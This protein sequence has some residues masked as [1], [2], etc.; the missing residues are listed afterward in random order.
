MKQILVRQDREWVTKDTRQFILVVPDDVKLSDLDKDVIADL[1]DKKEVY[2]DA[3]GPELNE[4]DQLEMTSVADPEC[5]TVV[6]LP[7]GWWPWGTGEMEKSA[8]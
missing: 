4:F 8:E 3:S 5:Y 2:W 7:E 1:A 6:E